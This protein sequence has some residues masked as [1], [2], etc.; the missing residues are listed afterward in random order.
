MNW[1]V[2]HL[3][4]KEVLNGAVQIGKLLW[5]VTWWDKNVI[6]KRKGSFRQGYLFWGKVVPKS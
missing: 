3:E 2:S 5:A 1:A 6:S 4:I